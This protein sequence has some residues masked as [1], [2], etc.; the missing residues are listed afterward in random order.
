MIKRLWGGD[1]G[2]P[3]TNKANLVLQVCSLYEGAAVR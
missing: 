3:Y 2:V 1:V